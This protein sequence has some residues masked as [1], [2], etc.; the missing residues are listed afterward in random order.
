M[1]KPYVFGAVAILQPPGDLLIYH[2][3]KPFELGIDRSV[4]ER[5]AKR[6]AV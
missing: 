5:K 6:L 1:E 3:A 2:H 4:N